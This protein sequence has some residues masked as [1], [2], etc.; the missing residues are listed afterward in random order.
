MQT[1][2][3]SYEFQGNFVRC[4]V[5]LRMMHRSHT[6]Y[7]PNSQS[8][9]NSKTH[10]P[11]LGQ[12]IFTIIRLQ[13]NWSNLGDTTVVNCLLVL[14]TVTLLPRSSSVSKV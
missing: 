9:P 8:Y 7:G 4:N 11:T 12:T 6:V 3:N 2:E 5:L 1:A 14:F 10:R 13:A